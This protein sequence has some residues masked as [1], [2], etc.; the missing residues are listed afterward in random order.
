MN[1]QQIAK[2]PQ[3]R[4]QQNVSNFRQRFASGSVEFLRWHAVLT[5]QISEFDGSLVIQNQQSIARDRSA[6]DLVDAYD[7]LFYEGGQ[8][9]GQFVNRNNFDARR[10][11]QDAVAGE[12][13]QG[14]S[15][16]SE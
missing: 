14:G 2:N 9:R 4:V 10:F 16:T 6:E 15:S 8:C 3:A 12:F 1:M 13:G 11:Q 7:F 5:E